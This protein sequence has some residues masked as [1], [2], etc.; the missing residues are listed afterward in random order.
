MNDKLRNGVIGQLK[1][2]SPEHN[3][4]YSTTL[5]AYK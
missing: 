1:V 3:Q 4:A 2:L 5:D